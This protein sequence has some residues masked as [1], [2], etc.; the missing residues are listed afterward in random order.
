MT[1]S[2]RTKA[3]VLR[4]TNYGEADRILQLLTPLGR[5]AVIAKGAR[6]ERSKLAG[7][8]ELFAISDIVIQTGRG[9]LGILTSA[10]L[11]KFFQRILID[12]ERLSS[13]YESVKLVTRASETLDTTEWYDI[14]SEVFAALNQPD[15]PLLLIKTW[16]YIRYATVLGYELGLVYDVAG[17]KLLQKQMYQYN[18]SEKG[19]Q[20]ADNGELSSEH[21][22]LLR[23]VAVKSIKTLAQIGGVSDI[24]PACF[25]VAR[26]HAA[27]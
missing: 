5:Y 27:I 15:T 14:L 20:L 24:L 25:S 18:I 12:Y 8:V 21:I 16:L 9:G 13:G 19:L 26:Q 3:I 23:L 7:G 17:N 1:K 2:L 10:R 22:K 4:R 6:R 11:L